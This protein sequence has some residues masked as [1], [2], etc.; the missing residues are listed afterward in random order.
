MDQL[1]NL[2]KEDK[3]VTLKELS[4]AIVEKKYKNSSVPKHAIPPV[5]LSESGANELTKAILAYFNDYKGIKANRQSSEGRYLKGQ[6]YTDWMGRKKEEKGF[7]IPRTG[8]AK[9][10]AD[11]TVTLPP[12]GRRCE[13]EVKYKK[14][15]Q[16]D[17]QKKYQ[18]EI[19]A[20]GG[21]YM[22]VRTWDDFQEQIRQYV[23]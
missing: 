10:A 5:K 2:V 7:Y 1:Q 4:A 3:S 19:E 17:V 21:I 16:S 6:E 11:I 8:S 18:A 14:D 9:G 22:I 13:I 15:V 12:M 20:M 23:K